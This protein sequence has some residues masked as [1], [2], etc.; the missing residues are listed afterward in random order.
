M[1]IHK[2]YLDGYYLTAEL[3]SVR[4]DKC[5]LGQK[6]ASRMR[7]EQD[8]K[9][10]PT[11]PRRRLFREQKRGFD[12]PGL[13]KLRGEHSSEGLARRRDPSPTELGALGYYRLAGGSPMFTEMEEQSPT[14]EE[15]LRRSNGRRQSAAR[16]IH[17]LEFAVACDAETRLP[18]CKRALKCGTSGHTENNRRGQSTPSIIS[19]PS[20]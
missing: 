3:R 10:S 18:A 1:A 13:T 6:L 20:F 12:F 7:L 5:S 17:D 8:C 19:H 11:I 16:A 4:S 14:E 2:M 9:K 15:D